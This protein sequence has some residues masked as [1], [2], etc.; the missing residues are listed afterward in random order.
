[1]FCFSIS[2]REMYVVHAGEL[3]HKYGSHDVAAGTAAGRDGAG[4]LFGC[5]VNVSTGFLT[6]TLNGRE[7]PNKFQ[8]CVPAN[9]IS[10]YSILLYFIKKK[11]DTMLAGDGFNV[12][13]DESK[14]NFQSSS[15]PG[16]D[17]T[18]CSAN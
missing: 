6:F 15:F 2:R 10:S 5:F 7:L 11:V 13:S 3:V 17:I 8:V 18:S 4:T 1:M 14:I 9:N 12:F 16:A